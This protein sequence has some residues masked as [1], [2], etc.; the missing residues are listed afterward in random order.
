MLAK[1]HEHIA[2]YALL[3]CMREATLHIARGTHKCAERRVFARHAW[4]SRLLPGRIIHDDMISSYL[5]TNTLCTPCHT[6][7]W[8]V[9]DIMVLHS[10]ARTQ[11]Q[12]AQNA[13]RVAQAI[14][15]TDPLLARYVL[16][17][18]LLDKFRFLYSFLDPVGCLCCS[19]SRSTPCLANASCS[20]KSILVGLLCS[21][22]PVTPYARHEA[23]LH[24]GAPA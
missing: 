20:E 24:V 18:K 21:M 11:C 14:I 12:P 19:S 15:I 16:R 17:S 22:L 1:A 23:N 2:D 9:R 5:G 3:R 13:S 6:R 4:I 10:V 7:H 8:I